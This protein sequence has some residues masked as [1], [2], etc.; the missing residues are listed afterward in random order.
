[1][2]STDLVRLLPVPGTFN[3][4]DLGG[5][6]VGTGL[7]RSGVLMRSDALAALG[8]PGREALRAL[9]LR[10]A[11]DLREPVERELDPPD[12]ADLGISVR[13]WPLVDGGLDL[14]RLKG[15]PDFYSELLDTCGERFAGAVGLLSR[16]AALPAVVFCSAGKDRTGLLCALILSA[17]GV[18]D[19]DVA[20]DYAFTESVVRGEFRA[21]L[22]AR[23]QAVG[24]SEQALAVK[25][26][27]PAELMLEVLADL[28]STHGGAERYLARH[29]LRAHELEAL[30]AGLVASS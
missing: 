29:G 4:R 25:L 10:T 21:R 12:L 5:Y 9:N 11:I 15:L 16:P 1:M 18:G 24:L 26:G 23:A 14:H 30:R 17:L 13:S 20:A 8:E 22:V 27:A 2:S 6:R 19:A 28:R 3:L 7:T